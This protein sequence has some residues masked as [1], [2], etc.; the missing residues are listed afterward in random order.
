ML[1]F[2]FMIFLSLF[3]MIKKKSAEDQQLVVEF[4]DCLFM[5]VKSID[6]APFYD[7]SIVF[8][9]CSDS[10]VFFIFHFIRIFFKLNCDYHTYLGEENCDITCTIGGR[11]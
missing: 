3:S 6:F 1:S 7:F 10:V 11:K 5:C 8:W 2:I 4:N 9:N